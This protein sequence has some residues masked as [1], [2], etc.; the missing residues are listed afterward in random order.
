MWYGHRLFSSAKVLCS[1]RLGHPENADCCVLAL[2]ALIEFTQ[3]IL[4]HCCVHLLELVHWDS[5]SAG[6]RRQLT[7]EKMVACDPGCKAKET[8]KRT[9][10]QH[11]GFQRGPPP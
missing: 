1:A 2:V 4:V 10:E 7:G 3:K 8:N 9:K 5:C 11:Q 6:T